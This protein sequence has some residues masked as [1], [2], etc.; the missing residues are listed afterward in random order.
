MTVTHYHDLAKA[1][2]LILEHHLDVALVSY[3]DVLGNHTDV[4]NLQGSLLV[5]HLNLEVTIEVGNHTIGGQRLH[6]GGTDDRLTR[7]VGD[8]TRDGYLV[9]C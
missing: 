5:L 9:L 4:C 7:F 1:L 8:I 2:V 6:D 3:T